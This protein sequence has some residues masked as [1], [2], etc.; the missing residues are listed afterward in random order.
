MNN[1]QPDT[2]ISIPKITEP[3]AMNPPRDDVRSTSWAGS[4]IEGSNILGVDYE[5]SKSEYPGDETTENEPL[6]SEDFDDGDS[7]SD[8]EHYADYDSGDDYY[9][10]PRRR[11]D[12]NSS[13]LSRSYRHQVTCT[14]TTP[15]PFEKLPPEIRSIIILFSMPDDPTRPLHSR[16]HNWNNKYDCSFAEDFEMPAPA[17]RIPTS[18][19]QVNKALSAEALRVFH[20]E[21]YIRLDVVPWGLRARGGVTTHLESFTH[22]AI[23]ATWRPFICMRNY[24]LNTKS[25][26]VVESIHSRYID[27]YQDSP[28]YEEGREIKSVHQHNIETSKSGFRNHEYY[29]GIWGDSGIEDV[30]ECLN[31]PTLDANGENVNDAFENAVQYSHTQ[32]AE[33]EKKRQERE[34]REAERQA[35]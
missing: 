21:T 30:W 22:H 17:E 34:E 8:D 4:H 33:S 10:H 11:F 23:L 15:F 9:Y 7:D 25:S 12:L 28:T 31:E 5:S 13:N 3:A 19:F 27:I 18:L 32:R 35:K 1:Q 24:H 16:E 6:E 2:T 20:H 29:W 14:P 26:S